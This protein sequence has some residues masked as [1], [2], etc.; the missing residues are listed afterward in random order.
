MREDESAPIDG[1]TALTP[2]QTIDF[3]GKLMQFNRAKFAY[4]IEH[5]QASGKTA[6]HEELLAHSIKHQAAT[7]LCTSHDVCREDLQAIIERAY[8]AAIR[9]IQTNPALESMRIF[10]TENSLPTEAANAD[11]PTLRPIFTE[12]KQLLERLFD[13]VVRAPAPELADEE[14]G[15]EFA[16]VKNNVTQVLQI[17]YAKLGNNDFIK[18]TNNATTIQQEVLAM[19]QTSARNENTEISEEVRAAVQTHVAYTLIQMP[20]LIP[21]EFAEPYR[22]MLHERRDELVEKL[23]LGI[24]GINES[25]KALRFVERIEDKIHER[26]RE[27]LPTR[28]PS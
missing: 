22:V 4:I 14:Q 7:I 10:I 18:G 19:L 27:M 24:F 12:T 6:T 21:E 25:E 1:H 23:G 28:S 20:R 2:A 11:H 8:I 26:V 5:T 15:S 17:V 9:D 16:R 3:A 13:E